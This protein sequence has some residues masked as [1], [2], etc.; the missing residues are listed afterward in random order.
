M[1]GVD[2]QTCSPC[3]WPI[4]I[5]HCKLRF[6][7]ILELL[8]PVFDN[9]SECRLNPTPGVCRESEHRDFW[10]FSQKTGTCVQITGCYTIRDRNIWLTRQMCRN[11]CIKKEYQTSSSVLPNFLA[12]ATKGPSTD[13]AAFR[14]GRRGRL[15]TRNTNPSTGDHQSTDIVVSDILTTIDIQGGG[16]GQGSP[17]VNIVPLRDTQSNR[18]DVSPTAGF[19]TVFNPVNP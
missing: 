1:V 5:R 19:Q 14:W 15:M 6:S 2:G 7:T 16:Q 3:A 9:V 4:H 18:V 13:N 17:R 10:T 11:N 12:D 8:P